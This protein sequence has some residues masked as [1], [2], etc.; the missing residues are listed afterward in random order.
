MDRDAPQI[1]PRKRTDFTERAHEEVRERLLRLWLGRLLV[2]D[3]LRVNLLRVRLLRMS[4]LRMRLLRVNLLRVM[5][6]L[7]MMLRLRVLL[8][9]MLHRLSLLGW[10]ALR[11][12]PGPE[13]P[14]LKIHE[15]V[16]RFELGLQILEPRIVFA[17]E[18]L[19]QRVVLCL[20]SVDLFLEQV[21]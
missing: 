8:R 1:F 2:M 11:R 9:M 10:R 21:G 12:L 17:F 3:L 13:T 5:L 4:L 7:R 20:M 15:P 6:R 16:Y 19:D 14:Q 18:L